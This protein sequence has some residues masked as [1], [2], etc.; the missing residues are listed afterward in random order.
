[1]KVK[2]KGTAN[3]HSYMSFC[4]LSLACSGRRADVVA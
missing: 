2:L 3:V 4:N 1:M